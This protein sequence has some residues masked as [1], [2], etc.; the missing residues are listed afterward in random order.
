MHII[1]IIHIEHLIY[2]RYFSKLFISVKPQSILSMILTELW[3]FTSPILQMRKS[4]SQRGWV[5]CLSSPAVGGKAEFKPMQYSSRGRVLNLYILGPP[6]MDLYVK[7]SAFVIQST[8]WFSERCRGD[9]CFLNSPSP[10][11]LLWHYF[12]N[13]CLHT[14]TLFLGLCSGTAV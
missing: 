3:I 6:N 12:M 4:E 14:W 11:S 5:T 13:N 2:T 10:F 8:V 7:V 9:C 1:F